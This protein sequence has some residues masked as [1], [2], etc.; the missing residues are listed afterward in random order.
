MPLAHPIGLASIWQFVECVYWPGQTRGRCPGRTPSRRRYKTNGRGPAGR[1]QQCKS[2]IDF[3]IWRTH[4]RRAK[5]R[6]RERNT[7]GSVW[8]RRGPT[9]VRQA[10]NGGPEPVRRRKAAEYTGAGVW[11]YRADQRSVGDGEIMS[12]V[13]TS[14]M[15]QELCIHQTFYITHAETKMYV[16]LVAFLRGTWEGPCPP[17]FGLACRLPH[18]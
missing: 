9:F 3:R 7:A 13:T 5:W 6:G 17:E 12:T 2:L 16:L 18:F 1:R 4:R 11:M 10:I 14:P 8:G 15:W